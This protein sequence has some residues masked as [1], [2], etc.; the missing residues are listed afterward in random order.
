MSA[1]ARSDPELP[2]L[3][4]HTLPESGP[5]VLDTV[6]GSRG[7]DAYPGHAW[8]VGGTS[9]ASNRKPAFFGHKKGLHIQ[10]AERVCPVQ[11]LMP[12]SGAFYQA[13]HKI[14]VIEIGRTDDP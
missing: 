3:F 11:V 7:E 6:A 4:D 10:K 9:Q 8:R 5:Y 14:P 12:P 2:G 1:A 13:A